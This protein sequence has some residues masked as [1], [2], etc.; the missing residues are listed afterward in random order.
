MVRCLA[1]VEP[2][3]VS[4]ISIADFP[5]VVRVVTALAKATKKRFDQQYFRKPKKKRRKKNR[6]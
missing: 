1:D 4:R 2:E 6:R 5:E 3:A